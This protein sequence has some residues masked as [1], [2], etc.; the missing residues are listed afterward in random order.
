MHELQEETKS[1]EV[2]RKESR[3]NPATSLGGGHA[4]LVSGSYPPCQDT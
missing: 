4:R 1:D 3:L 2:A